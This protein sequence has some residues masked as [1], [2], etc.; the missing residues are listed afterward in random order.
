MGAPLD[1][2]TLG[3][4][5]DAHQPLALP[6]LNFELP[7]WPPTGSTAAVE[8]AAARACHAQPG[9]QRWRGCAGPQ[10]AALL[11]PLWG[12]GVAR[13]HPAAVADLYA[14][15]A[16]A[17]RG[18]SIYMPAHLLATNTTPVSNMNAPSQPTGM[19]SQH[20]QLILE[21][22]LR[23][24][25]SGT[26]RSACQSVFGPG[27]C[28]DLGLAMKTGTSLF[29]H[30]TLTATQ[31]ATHCAQVFV[32]EDK[33]RASEK[34]SQEGLPPA[35]RKE[36]VACALY[37]MKWA[38]LIEPLPKAKSTKAG[39]G[40]T[41]DDALLT[42]VLAERNHHAGTGWVDAAGDK[43]PNVAAQVALLLHQQRLAAPTPGPA[44]SRQTPITP[45]A[46]KNLNQ[47]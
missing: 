47:R 25:L 46:K 10:L 44:P 36:A 17:A 9:K 41:V 19:A 2:L 14:R 22:L 1:L 6:V 26:A 18:Q 20:A 15:L 5:A 4:R 21:G 38:V 11:G 12:Q 29:P 34:A 24:P 39:H 43:G 33:F 35:L 13:S 40:T 7:T 32:E 42:V 27:G 45:V 30:E 16:A 31:R 3:E 28:T 23:V 37:P 8:M